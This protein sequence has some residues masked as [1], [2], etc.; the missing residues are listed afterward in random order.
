VDST[1][2]IEELVY[3]L[4]ENGNYYLRLRGATSSGDDF[5]ATISAAPETIL[6]LPPGSH[7]NGIVGSSGQLF[8]FT[9]NDNGR[10]TAQLA[11]SLNR[12][13]LVAEIYDADSNLVESINNGQSGTAEEIT[14]SGETG[15]YYTL[16][17]YDVFQGA[18]PFELTVQ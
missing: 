15:L 10:F 18:G 4:P 9:P 3:T 16:R 2:G 14:F 6:D 13:D 7:V 12:M 8:I 17:I 1:L 5:Q 11:S